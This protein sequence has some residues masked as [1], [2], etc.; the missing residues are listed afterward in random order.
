MT[1]Q[2]NLERD[3]RKTLW[4][5][6]ALFTL[7]Q[8]ALFY[9]DVRKSRLELTSAVLSYTENIARAHLE[10]SSV[11]YLQRDL[12]HFQIT[13][14]RSLGTNI[15]VAVKRGGT[16]IATVGNPRDFFLTSEVTSFASVGGNQVQ[17]SVLVDVSDILIKRT[18]P[19]AAAV[20]LLLV[21]FAFL[22]R[23]TQARLSEALL[24]LKRLA[25]W[26]EFSLHQMTASEAGSAPGGRGSGLPGKSETELETLAGA[27]DDL[28]EHRASVNGQRTELRDEQRDELARIAHDIRSPLSALN[29][30]AHPKTQIN[31][32]SRELLQMTIQRIQGIADSL[33]T[34]SG[35]QAR[36]SV[37][38]PKTSLS[39]VLEPLLQEKQQRWNTKPGLRF[40]WDMQAVRNHFVVGLSQSDLS[41]V[42]SNLIDNAIEA[43]P[44]DVTISISSSL[45]GSRLRMTISDTGKGMSAEVIGK[46]GRPGATFGK[47]GGTGLGVYSVR[48][49]L[50]SVGG[51]LKYDSVEGKGTEVTIYFPC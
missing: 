29:L 3:F 33:L 7:M 25:A 1:L 41:R 23:Q 45:E 43:T 35:Q 13:L 10:E 40:V 30:F 5:G 2:E 47:A 12:Q 44:G 32:D 16:L 28:L 11:I 39:K 51:E 49:I 8:I 4:V 14:S 50:E 20:A 21:I 15:S 37:L 24:P 19:F 36:P 42:L 48:R 38:R 27:L 17:V 26:A 46:I 34:V 18:L 9:L 22:R 6:F 31:T